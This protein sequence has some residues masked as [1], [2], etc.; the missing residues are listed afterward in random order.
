MDDLFSEKALQK[1]DKEDLKVMQ[2]YSTNQYLEVLSTAD[3]NTSFE[4]LLKIKFL[5]QKMLPKMPR[6]YILRQVFD[7]KHCTLTLR[8][9]SNEDN[10]I[11]AICY[12]PAFDRRLIEIVFFAVESEFQ[13]NGFGTFMFN[14]FKEISKLQFK[15]YLNEGEKYKERNLIIK[16]LSIFDNHRSK[17]SINL[18]EN[19]TVETQNYNDNDQNTS[20]E[21]Y[22]DMTNLYLLTYADNSA[23][24]FFRKQGFTTHPVSTQWIHYI[25]DYDGGTLME[26][27]LYKK[28]NYLKKKEL[29]INLRTRILEEMKKHN[30][31]HIVKQNYDREKANHIYEELKK[32]NKISERSREE[33][34]KDFLHFIICSLQSNPS[35][36][37]FL[38]PVNVKDV[39]DYLDVIKNPIDLGTIFNKYKDGV[40]QTLRHFTDDIMLM[41]NNC[42]TYNGIDTQYYKCGEII[43]HAYEDLLAKY[44]DIIK[45][46]KYDQ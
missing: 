44:I 7:K 28:I 10:I 25:K 46:W 39:P 32:E 41:V 37:P 42:Y 35:A 22:T 18:A 45:M 8:G 30:E 27:K 21:E 33:F 5:F 2:F 19:L 16:D 43:Q 36:W 12:R 26:C 14:C 15:T 17:E 24:G 1:L 29:I 40:Y 11:A 23:I 31:Y 9:G 13:I 38:E 3:K 4:R 20:A 34:L 6:E